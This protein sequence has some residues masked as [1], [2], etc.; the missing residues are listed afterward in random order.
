M[1]LSGAFSDKKLIAELTPKMFLEVEAVHFN[2][3]NPFTYTSGRVSP[4]YVDCRK[5]ISF[6]RLRQ[7]MMSFG[8]STIFR[9]VG[10]EKF[11]AVAGGETAGIPFAT[12]MAERLM[13]PMQYV[14][15]K[16]KGFARDAQIE[17]HLVE[18]QR[19]LLVKI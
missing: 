17:G 11:D 9:D 6:P 12:M 19:T 8:V 2:A 1:M 18:G 15:K 7:T 16:P 10:V 14:R 13:L 4:V 3:E 5:L